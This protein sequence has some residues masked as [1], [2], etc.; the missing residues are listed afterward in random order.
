MQILSELAE[1]K[2]DD[3]YWA[4]VGSLDSALGIIE[5]LKERA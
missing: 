3:R 4:L 2:D 5:P 1:D